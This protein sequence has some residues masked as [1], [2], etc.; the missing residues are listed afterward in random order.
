MNIND[1]LFLNLINY[2]NTQINNANDYQIAKIILEN[3]SKSKTITLESL[4]NEACIS[5]ASISRFVKKAN[6]SSFQQF[7]DVCYQGGLGISHH[8]HLAHVKRF[9]QKENQFICD[10][11]FDDIMANLIATK[12]NLNIETLTTLLK[13]MKNAHSVSFYGDDHTLSQFYTLQIDFLTSHIP[14]YLFKKEE[15]QFLHSKTLKRNDV[16]IFFNVETDFITPSQREMI[17]NLNQQGVYLILFTQDNK[18]DLFSYF[19]DIYRFGINHTANFGFYSLQYLSQI[20]SELFY[21]V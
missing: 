7:R 20:M 21:R 1:G 10:S 4:S 11:I 8:R 18:N 5:Q 14:T 12:Q 15:I 2:C 13:L 6:F 17:K 16:A 3:L 9:N 19:N